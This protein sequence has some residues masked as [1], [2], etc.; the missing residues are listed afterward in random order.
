[1]DHLNGMT[2]ATGCQTKVRATLKATMERFY[3]LPQSIRN[4]AA[5]SPGSVLLESSLHSG[6]SQCSYLFL[7][8]ESTIELHDVSKLPEFFHQIEEA[9]RRGR[10]VA[11]YLSYEA[12]MGFEPHLFP[13]LNQTRTLPLGWFGVY[14][15]PVIFQHQ[16]LLDKEDSLSLPN[17]IS[18]MEMAISEATYASKIAHIHNLIESGDCYQA[19][20]T[21]FAHWKNHT[22]A[23]ELFGH[24]MQAQPVEFGALLNLG[25][26]QILSASPELFFKSDGEKIITKPMKGTAPRGRTLE[27]DARIADWLAADEKNRSENLM[28]VDLLR[29]DLGRVCQ[30]GS[31]NVSKLFHVER[32]PTLFQM[33]STVEGT[34]NADTSHYDLFRA[35]FPS[36]S[37]VGA[38]KIRTM[39]ILREMEEQP[40]EVYTGAIGFFAPDRSATFSVAIRT[41]VLQAEEARMGVGSGIVYDSDA[42]A[43]YAECLTKTLFLTRSTIPFDLIETFLWDRSYTFLDEHL[44]RLQASAAYFDFYFEEQQVRDALLKASHAFGCSEIQRVR[45]LLSKYGDVSVTA[46]SLSLPANERISILLRHETTNSTDPFLFHK[47]TRREIYDRGLQQAQKQ[48]CADAIFCNEHG[49]LT[50]GSIHNLVLVRDQKWFTPPLACGV[51][52]GIYRKHLMDKQTVQERVLRLEDLLDAE[53]I[54]LCNSVRG[55]RRVG[56]VLQEVPNGETRCIWQEKESLF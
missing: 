6:G 56:R 2:P 43:E 39:Q 11:G 41:V 1:M 40:R 3:P 30:H 31:V 7:H 32:Y 55:L 52:S 53:Q 13:H 47:T 29:N 44:A 46:S 16:T 26:T 18:Q 10:Y 25:E 21:T 33:T 12:G 35:L 5:E 8:P 27:E 49:E 4:Q 54:Y 20:F 14:D 51:L 9:Q 22:S 38:P 42:N 17:N 45:L 37:I 15:T 50:E 36:G 19:N 48:R 28:I 34:L 23:A 24:M